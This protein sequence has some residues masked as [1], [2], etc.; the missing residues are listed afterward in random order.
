MIQRTDAHRASPAISPFPVGT[1]AWK[2]F[3]MPMSFSDLRPRHMKAILIALLIGLLLPLTLTGTPPA[4]TKPKADDPIQSL[5]ILP[6]TIEFSDAR[7]QRTL[8]VI[9][10]TKS[11]QTVDLTYKAKFEFD[12]KLLAMD[13]DH[14]FRGLTVGKT[15]IKVS[16][17]GQQADLPVNI[18]SAA[19]PPVDFIKDV[20]PVL[21]RAGCNQG[22]CHGS[23]QGK[24]GFKLSLRGYDPDFDYHALVTELS[25]R[26]FDRVNPAE[27]LMLLKSTGEIAHEGKQ[28]VAPGSRHYQILHDWIAEGIRSPVSPAA[29]PTKIQIIPSEVELPMPNMSQRVLVIAHYADGSTRDVTRD[30]VMESSNIEVVAVKGNNVTGLRRGEGAVLVRYEGQYAAVEMS[31]MGDRSGFAWK[32]TEEFNYIDKHINAKLQKRKILPSGLCTDA[33]F[34]RRLYLDLTGQPPTAAVARQFVEDKTPSAQKRAALIARLIGSP[35]YVEYWSNK[36]ADLLQCNTKMLG[37][38]GVWVFRQ[39]IR[40]S[41]EQNKPYDQFVKEILSASGSSLRNPA[42][43]YYRALRETGKMTEDISQTFLGVRFNCNKCHDHPFER[44]TQAQYYQFGAYFAQVAFKKGSLPGEEMVYSSY[45]GGE[46]THPKTNMAVAPLAPF[47]QSADP[48]SAGRRE[49]FV[50]WIASRDNPLFARSYVN[51]VWAYLLGRGIIDPID[52]IRA[53][54]PPVNGPLLD[55]LTKD[56]IDSNFDTAKLL[57]TICSSAT[58]QRSIAAN[59]WNIDDHLNFSHAGAR[60][61]TAEQLLDA[62]AVSTG[63]RPAVPGMPAGT[64]AA[65]IPQAVIPGMDMAVLFGRPDRESACECARTSNV[66]LAHALSMINGKTINDAVVDPSNLLVRVVNEEKDNRKVIEFL[67]Y[68]ILSRPPTESE[69]K[70]DLGTGAERMERAQDLAWALLNSAGFLFNR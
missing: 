2:V 59:E 44:W 19:K 34:V 41:V 30:A 16:A 48:A 7:D 54:N 18:R 45:N 43:N 46:V 70:E 25:G 20:Q 69:M 3:L 5:Q 28:A 64:R 21:A 33:D 36:W 13:K 23:A 66:S 42:V 9:G 58:Y 22:T 32:P 12:A 40:D 39:W 49:A 55:A 11:G 14:Y 52:D 51:R 47:G 26:R 61:L 15:S 17:A 24:N 38:R 68:S 67:Y 53:G 37:E 63:V 6:E 4:D 62:L 50:D 10:R 60:R 29:R 1:L 57:K 27:S 8:L 35:D 56:F 65:A 31:I